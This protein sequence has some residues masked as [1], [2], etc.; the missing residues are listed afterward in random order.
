MIKTLYVS[1]L[2][3]SV[4]N[5]LAAEPEELRLMTYNI[6]HA[7]GMDGRLDCERIARVLLSKSPDCVAIQ[8]IDSATTRVKG[9][10]ILQEIAGNMKMFPVF[11]ATM[12][13]QGGKYGI[14][15]LCKEKP[16]TVY[17]VPLPGREEVRMLLIAEFE[18]FCIGCTHFSLTREDRRLSIEKIRDS[19]KMFQK[20]FILMGDMNMQ[21]NDSEADLLSR[22]FICLSGL[23]VKTY[24]ADYPTEC[25]DYIWGDK[26][27]EDKYK[28][29]E[30]EIVS[31]TIASDHRPIYVRMSIK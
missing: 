20:P 14:G 31:D 24:P 10:D 17:H 13:Y 26:K 12:P 2:L 4:C 1:I 28:V 9:L 27:Y 3:L 23:D 15:L 21:P 11:S 8:E 30:T 18:R 22:D 5:L 29:L 7:E 16:I 6:H 25:I 19:L